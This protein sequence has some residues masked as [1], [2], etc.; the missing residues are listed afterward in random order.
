MID[1]VYILGTGSKHANLELRYSLRSVDKFM[2][3]IRHVYVVGHKP[4]FIHNVIH[5]PA[6]DPYPLPAGKD[7]NIIRKM[8]IACGIE[9]ISD[10]IVF[11]DDDFILCDLC[12][13]PRLPHYYDGTL[14]DYAD[15]CTTMYKETLNNTIS[16]LRT[17]GADKRNFNL[18]CPWRVDKK[19]FPS[20]MAGFNF[21]QHNGLAIQSIYY[22]MIDVLGKKMPDLK[23]NTRMK[24]DDILIA[25][26]DRK[27]FSFGDKGLNHDMERVLEYMFPQPS[28]YEN[29]ANS[30][31]CILP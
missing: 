28:K 30:N 1:L 5:I 2:G 8:I 17:Y 10:E 19:L 21:N 15:R 23:I 11:F 9:G 20:V 25:I 4:D 22:N 31:T 13:A 26:K 29:D 18:H 12:W 14:Q 7:R 6:E 16:A 27:F 24:Y 3:G